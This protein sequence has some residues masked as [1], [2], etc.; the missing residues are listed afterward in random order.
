[1]NN[2]DSPL[3]RAN[4]PLPNEFEEFLKVLDEQTIFVPIDMDT[5]YTRVVKWIEALAK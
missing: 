3:T 4:R 5:S 1:M 2:F